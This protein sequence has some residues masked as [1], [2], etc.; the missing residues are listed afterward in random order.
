MGRHAPQRI[1]GGLGTMR[2]EAATQDDFAFGLNPCAPDVTSVKVIEHLNLRVE[3]AD[4]L[5]GT[6]RFEPSH[7]SGVFEAL[8]DPDF[9]SQVT[10]SHGTV[11]WPGE[12]DMAPDAMYDAIQQHQEWVLE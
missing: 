5:V 8:R 2:I 11:T 4:G 3:F 12:L 9:F 6:V 7:L 1:D 10:V